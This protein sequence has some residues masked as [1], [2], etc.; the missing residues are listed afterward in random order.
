MMMMMM[1][2]ILGEHTI[3]LEFAFYKGALNFRL[4]AKLSLAQ[5]AESAE[6]TDFFSAGGG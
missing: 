3:S 6:Y 2:S 1:I 4:W 5:T